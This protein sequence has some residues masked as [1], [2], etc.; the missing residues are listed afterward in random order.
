M[1]KAALAS[2]L[3]PGILLCSD[4]SH[5]DGYG[6]AGCGLG[7]IIISDNGI[8]QI[9]AATFNATSASQTFGIT[10]GTSNC[11]ADGVVQADREQEMF[12]EVNLRNLRRDMAAG[13]GEYLAALGG[14]MGCEDSAQPELGAFAQAHYEQVFATQQATRRTPQEVLYTFKAQMTHDPELARSCSRL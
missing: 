11:T 9:F 8:V 5:A 4:T 6:M 7:S 14:L 12:V 3:L 13:G 2:L 1:R 10:T